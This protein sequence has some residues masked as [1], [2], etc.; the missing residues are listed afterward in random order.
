MAVFKACLQGQQMR[1]SHVQN[2]LIVDLLSSGHEQLSGLGAHL[3]RL[4]SASQAE[5]LALFGSM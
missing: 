5:L 1:R 2:Q 3:T 4:E